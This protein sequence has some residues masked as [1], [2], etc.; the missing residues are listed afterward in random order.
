MGDPTM[1]SSDP[2]ATDKEKPPPTKD[3]M[4]EYMKNFFTKLFAASFI[5]LLV[6]AIMYWGVNVILNNKIV[7][8]FKTG[9]ENAWSTEPMIQDGNDYKEN[10]EYFWSK[11]RKIIIKIFS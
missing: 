4:E 9:Y 5:L 8:I 10:P 2:M 7:T 3:D 1:S 6:L 11:F